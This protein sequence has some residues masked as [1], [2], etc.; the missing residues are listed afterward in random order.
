M[1]GALITFA[2]RL[3]YSSYGNGIRLTP[4][5]DQQ[6]AGLIMWIPAGACY[7]AA[8]IG[9]AAAWLRHAGDKDR[10][11]LVNRQ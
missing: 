1:L 5:E 8:G 7:L 4:M 3:I 9:F 6:L 2:P 10:A 11:A